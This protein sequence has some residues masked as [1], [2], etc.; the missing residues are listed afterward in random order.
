M[1]GSILADQL[2]NI[3]EEI[4]A[5]YEEGAVPQQVN[6]KCLY[7][8]WLTRTEESMKFLEAVCR[9]DNVMLFKNI[10]C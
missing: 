6:I 4:N 1:T 3:E 5:I 10:S 2:E 7:V 9:I 8:S